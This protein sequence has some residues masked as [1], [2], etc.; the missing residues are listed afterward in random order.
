MPPKIYKKARPLPDAGPPPPVSSRAKES[1]AKKIASLPPPKKD[2]EYV[3]A[4][5]SS[6]KSDT[7]VR[8]SAAGERERVLQEAGEILS[9]YENALLPT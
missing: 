1:N 4:S 5:K 2:Q 9:N 3:T 8:I 7:L 6:G